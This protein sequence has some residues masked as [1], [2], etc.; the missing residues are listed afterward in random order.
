MGPEQ[1]VTI[2]PDVRH[3]VTTRGGDYFFLPGLGAMRYLLE[4]SYHV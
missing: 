1:R 4:G 2:C 3:F